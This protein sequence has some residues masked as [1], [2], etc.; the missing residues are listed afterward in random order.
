VPGVNA[1]GE[2]EADFGGDPWRWIADEWKRIQA[3]TYQH[4]VDD[5][6]LAPAMTER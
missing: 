3:G 2:Y 1:G 5:Y 4:Y 6:R